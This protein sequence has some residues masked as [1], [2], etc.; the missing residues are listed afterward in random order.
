M[1]ADVS[2]AGLVVVGR[3][4]F[5]ADPLTAEIEAATPTYL[6]VRYQADDVRT[7]DGSATPRRCGIRV[8]VADRDVPQLR[9]EDRRALQSPCSHG[10]TAR[11]MPG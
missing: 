2:A 6:G 8:P 4:L 11:W 7:E 3:P 5:V 1:I 9:R 10:W